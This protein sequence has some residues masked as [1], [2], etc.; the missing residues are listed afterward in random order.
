[1]IDVMEDKE[2]NEEEED[3]DHWKGTAMLNGQG[4]CY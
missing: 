3:G 1:M 4:R 2:A